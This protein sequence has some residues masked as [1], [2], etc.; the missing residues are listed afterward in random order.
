M[1]SWNGVIVWYRLLLTTARRRAIVG[2]RWGRRRGIAG[3]V[4]AY[5]GT[6]IR[7]GGMLFSPIDRSLRL[8]NAVSER[9]VLMKDW[10]RI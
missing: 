6:G 9:S 10:Q 8:D 3:I 5:N 7:Q 1:L 2:G 4:L